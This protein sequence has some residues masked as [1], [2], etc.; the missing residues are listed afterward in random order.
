[1]TNS[2]KASDNTHSLERFDTNWPDGFYE[3]TAGA[4]I[5]EPLIRELQGEYEERLEL[6]DNQSE[7][8]T[9]KL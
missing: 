5:G 9:E 1:M 6:N 4:W 3:A 7:T 2:I 8:L